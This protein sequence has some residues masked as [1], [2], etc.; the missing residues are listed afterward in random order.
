MQKPFKIS[1]KTFKKPLKF[2]VGRSI[3]TLNLSSANSHHKSGAFSKLCCCLKRVYHS[4]SNKI[5]EYYP[6]VLNFIVKSLWS[7]K[8][9]PT[10]LSNQIPSPLK[11]DS[12]LK[13]KRQNR[14]ACFSSCANNRS[15]NK[16]TQSTL[17]LSSIVLEWRSFHQN[18]IMKQQDPS[19]ISQAYIKLVHV[20][21]QSQSF[22]NRAQSISR[23]IR[24][25]QTIQE[26]EQG[27]KQIHIKYG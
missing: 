25:A 15:S 5:L 23:E 20:R 3:F 9:L 2:Q 21:L 8:S 22:S 19:T 7:M 18:M 4:Q 13:T 24:R 14:N 26:E 11:F 16:A 12:Y 6:I 1:T 17:I 10:T 27:T